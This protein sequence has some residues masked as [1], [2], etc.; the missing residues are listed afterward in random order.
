MD[1][2][3]LWQA[4]LGEMQRRVT[5]SY[6]ENWLRN[7]NILGFDNDVAI[8]AA[9]NKSTASTI[10]NRN[11]VEIEDL[12]SQ[13]V[14]R[15]IRVEFVE[16]GGDS[17]ES[18]PGSQRVTPAP[19]VP[20]S[21][22]RGRRRTGFGS[23]IAAPVPQPNQQLTLQV[24]PA[25]GLNTRYTFDHYVV[26][27]SNRFAHAASMAVAENPGVSHNPLFVYG[28]VGLGKTH[29]LHAIGHRALELRP[30]LSVKYATSET[31]TNEVIEAIRRGGAGNEEFRARYRS[32]DILM[33]DDVQFIAGKEQTQE[34]FFNTFNSL[35]MKGKQ[36]VV[37]ADKPPAAIHVL[38]ERLRS[39]FQGG[40][41]AD[42][43]MPDYEMRIAIL[44]K[45]CEETN[46]SIPADVIEYIAHREQTNIRDLGG[47]LET[48]VSRAQ[49]LGAPLTLHLAMEAMTDSSFRGR[50]VRPSEE[51][52]I[53]AV[54]EHF[55]VTRDDLR[56]RSR[57]Q[58][59]VRPRH[60]A[61]F[62]LKEETAASL[63][64]IGSLFDG[65]DHS[66]VLHGIEN[67]KNEQQTNTTLRADLM[68]IREAIFGNTYR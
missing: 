34:E 5:K 33:I 7:T 14:G 10:R 16:R 48:I 43:Q 32:V 9:P 47:R 20:S 31:F 25:H 21:V 51:M 2:R 67:V 36:I 6:Y 41:I 3:P 39:R 22:D 65:R 15:P 58:V 50:R 49:F 54:A 66:T 63:D 59:Y 8:V 46:V 12:F 60:V 40:L 37:T 62:L 35:Y 27:S 68:K 44:R 23:P 61:M 38:E 1:A 4:V 56:G 57:R 17:A 29:L 42:V 26:G 24:Q 45:K 30:H 19:K 64:H 28:G 53:D 18:T 13:I 11:G 55:K 52:V